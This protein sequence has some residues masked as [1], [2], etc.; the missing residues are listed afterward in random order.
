MNV[1]EN[2]GTDRIY[3]VKY[4]ARS[5]GLGAYIYNILYISNYI[6]NYISAPEVS[7]P[8][9]WTLYENEHGPLQTDGLTADSVIGCTFCSWVE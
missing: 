5:R 6:S 7:I 4:Y 3:F 9:L 1:P 2:G 8:Y